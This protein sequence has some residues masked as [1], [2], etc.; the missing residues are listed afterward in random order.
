[1][2]DATLLEV[3]GLRVAFGHRNAG[4]AHQVLDGVEL[5][6]GRGELVGVIGETGSGKTTLGRAIVG[7]VSID[8]GTITLEGKRISSLRRRP[9]RALRRNG[10]VQLIFQDPLRSLDPQQTVAAIVAEGL[11]IQGQLDR[12]AQRAA[13]LRALELVG[14]DPELA[15]RRPGEISGGQRQRVAIARS[16]ALAPKL[17]ICDEPV[18]ALDASNRS[19]ILALLGRLRTELGI[20]MLIISHDLV[21]LVEVVDRV[22]VLHDGRIVEQGPID[23]VFAAPAHAYTELLIASAPALERERNRR[24]GNHSPALS[25]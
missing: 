12:D 8:A 10:A 3:A 13:A 22:A 14:L 7:L 9:R 17:L 5:S 20:A 4:A 25:A 1:V 23:R 15:T 18:S 19:H 6:V 24:L 16:L 21:S 2:P 11:A